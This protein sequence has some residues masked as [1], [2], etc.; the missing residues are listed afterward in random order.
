LN[1]PDHPRDGSVQ[2]AD[3]PAQFSHLLSCRVENDGKGE[4]DIPLLAQKDLKINHFVKSLRILI[5]KLPYLGPRELRACLFLHVPPS[6]EVLCDLCE[7]T[8][9]A[10]DLLQAV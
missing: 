8:E 10:D 5:E 9:L 4:D 7:S 3:L 1:R 2:V 6:M